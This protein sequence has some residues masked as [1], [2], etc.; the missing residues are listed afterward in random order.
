M[1]LLFGLALLVCNLVS[2]A[3]AQPAPKAVVTGLTNPESAAIDAEGHVFVSVIGQRDHN[4]DG[5]VLKIEHGKAVPFALGL[6][7][8]KGLV[9]HQGAL[10]VA[11]RNRVWR[12][13]RNGKTEVFVPASAF[14]TPPLY[15][16]FSTH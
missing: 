14:P 3:S 15:S 1:R 16:T 10:F 2:Q 9:S 4:G 13:D 6:D 7:D 8:P 5:A 11:D 12:I